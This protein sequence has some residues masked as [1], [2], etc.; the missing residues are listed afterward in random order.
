M[1]R[2][3]L[4]ITSTIAGLI[5]LFSY[6]TSW[7]PTSSSTVTTTSQNNNGVGIVSGGT[8]VPTAGGASPDPATSAGASATA[9]PRTPAKLNDATVNGSIAQTIWGPVQVQ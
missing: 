8:P 4:Y 3:A 9:T 7:G 2:I 1:R 6:R 5:L